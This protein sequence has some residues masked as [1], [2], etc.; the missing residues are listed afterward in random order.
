MVKLSVVI[1]TYNEASQIADFCRALVFILETQPVDFEIII[2]DDDSPDNTWKIV[3]AMSVVDKRI[4]LLR[5]KY[6]KGL[7]SAGGLAG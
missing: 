7:A 4:R 2:V 1:P 5:R 6:S 3:E